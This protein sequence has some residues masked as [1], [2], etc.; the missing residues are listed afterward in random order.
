MLYCRHPQIEPKIPHHFPLPPLFASPLRNSLLFPTIFLPLPTPLL[1]AKPPSESRTPA[2]PSP[3]PDAAAVNRCR[4]L[5]LSQPPQP[6][7]LSASACP[8]R[9]SRQRPPPALLAQE[10]DCEAIRKS[11]PAPL[12]TFPVPPSPASGHS[13]NVTLFA[14]H[15]R[16]PVKGRSLV[17]APF[18]RLRFKLLSFFVSFFLC[19]CV[20]VCLFV[21]TDGPFVPGV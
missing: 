10:A 13:R 1:S 7:R 6:R 21:Q 3:S 16:L 15:H 8:Q 2:A 14:A 9:S 4:R 12:L 19:V 17:D 20:C 11:S 5:Q 18:A